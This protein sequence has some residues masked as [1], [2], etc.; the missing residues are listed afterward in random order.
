[1]THVADELARYLDWPHPWGAYRLANRTARSVAVLPFAMLSRACRVMTPFI[2]RDLGR[3]LLSLPTAALADGRLRDEA[4]AR[5]FPQHAHLP[6]EDPAKAAG[7]VPGYYRRLSFAL[8]REALRRTASPLV[9]RGFLASR[10]ARSAATG[11][12]PWFETRR[13]VFL[14]Q[15]E[16]VMQSGA[17]LS[18]PSDT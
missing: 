12:Q 11:S 5:A 6:Y 7:A 15:L 9:R 2:D 10:L 1:V 8:A 4:I 18:E 17:A 16:E 13:A 14:M 3:F